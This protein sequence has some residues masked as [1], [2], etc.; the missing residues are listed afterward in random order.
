M[1]EEL[2]II[3][4]G[5]TLDKVHDTFAE[6]LAFDPNGKSHM[7]E[8]LASARC[9]FP[10]TQ[11]IFLKDSLDFTDEDR[12][13]IKAEI[14]NATEEAIVLTHGTGTMAQTACFLADQQIEKTIVLT[15]AIRPYSFAGS[16]AQFNLGGAVIAAQTL[17]HG[18]WAIMNG[19][20]FPADRVKK[21]VQSGRFDL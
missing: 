9:H 3:V 14:C 12:A 2:L 20:V 4:T 15:G 10:Q 13:F 5:G 8:I 17:P 1:R 11:L 7:P 18:V 19:R 16:D 6:A 21:D